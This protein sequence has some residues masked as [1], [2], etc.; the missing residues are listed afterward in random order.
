MMRKVERFGFGVILATL[1]LVP[2]PAR[3]D[4]SK[5]VETPD[6]FEGAVSVTEVQVPVTVVGKDGLPVRDL[7]REDFQLTDNGRKQ[8][9][10]GFQVIDL[11]SL[12]PGRSRTE[13]E[14]AVPAAARRY[15]LLLFDHSF[16]DSGSIRRAQEASRRFVVESLHPTDLA[17]V[18]VLTAES[19]PSLVVTFT[20]DR[21]QIARGI[22]AVAS[23]N[24]RQIAES[25]DPLRFLIQATGS[26]S[27]TMASQEA[28]VS[29]EY[30]RDS[31]AQIQGYLDVIRQQAG[32]AERSF[33]RGKIE[34]WSASMSQLGTALNSLRGRKYVVYFSEGFDSQL[35]FGQAQVSSVTVGGQELSP[36]EQNQFGVLDTED[37][38]GSGGLRNSVDRMLQEFRRSD[39]IIE[40]VDIS[41]AGASGGGVNSSSGSQGSLFYLAN[42]TGGEIIRAGADLDEHLEVMLRRSAV[43]Y[44]L[45]FQPTRI[46]LDGSYHRLKVKA[47]LSKENRL[48]H[49]AGYYAP[50][51]F[52]E[53]PRVEKDLLLADAIAGATPSKD[54]TIHVLAAPFPANEARAYVP[55]VLEVAGET[56]LVGHEG[57][58]LPIEIYVYVSDEHGEMADFF[59]HVL[60]FNLAGRWD[61]FRR[62]GLKYYGHL[63]LDA[64]SDYLL[65]VVVRNG[66]TGRTG[67][68]T[69]ALD[70]PDYSTHQPV[71]LPPFL[72]EP[73]ARWFMVR[74][75]PPEEQQNEWMIYPFTIHG[76]PFV[77]AVWPVL[78]ADEEIELCLIAYN[79]GVEK[80][81]LTGAVLSEDGSELAVGSF[82]LTDHII[83]TQTGV[84]KMVVR[85][86]PQGLNPGAYTLRLNLVDPSWDGPAQQQV[87]ITIAD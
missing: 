1:L 68:E 52:D 45:T 25:Q 66:K 5:A 22:D 35:L 86:N 38:Y 17:A 78:R 63:D 74:E 41:A 80:F 51:P 43:T 29:E 26:A 20:P 24:F 64:G 73:P 47:D 2:D 21:A 70:V 31:D 27:G 61:A 67:V 72:V 7:R 84:D 79:L 15:F 76:E 53:L 49:R 8:E 11:E 42:E 19:G 82:D 57:E 58:H 9:I 13:I 62:T 60:T 33:D 3:G 83:A 6:R 77:P 85:F 39:C 23:P 30:F 40:A 65:R 37:V 59:T 87:S 54:V 18:A 48:T 36:L 32:S 12:E 71:L 56:L 46:K 34:S 16:S 14:S 10:S 44:L 55:V 81:E 4:K 75:Q 50:R 69:L 28:T